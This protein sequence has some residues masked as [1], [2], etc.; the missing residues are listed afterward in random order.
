MASRRMIDPAFWQSETVASFSFFQR[1][2]FTGLFSNADDQGRLKAH[3]VLLRS[4]V[5]PYDDFPAS[6]IEDAIEAF[7]ESGSII[8]YIIDG[9]AYLQ[10]TNWW[11]WQHQ[12]WAW[13][14]K[15][16]PPPDWTDRHHYR[17]GNVQVYEN[18]PGHENTAGP[19]EDDD[20][21]EVAPERGQSGATV[22]PAP[23]IDTNNST[24]DSTDISD[25]TS[26]STKEHDSAVAGLLMAWGMNDDVI[27]ALLIEYGYDVVAAMRLHVAS[28]DGIDNPAGLLI[29]KLA[30]GDRAPPAADTSTRR[31]IEGEYA[32][33]IEH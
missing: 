25:S 13:P 7:S 17:K 33:V 1:L 4:L 3:P 6:E 5:F 14:S 12:G 18:W 22:G 21:A 28:M 26:T 27:G 8:A 31:Y 10:L 23:S 9:V 24:S 11:R 30:N 16:P 29:S 32:D 2:F 15:L 19:V 20:G